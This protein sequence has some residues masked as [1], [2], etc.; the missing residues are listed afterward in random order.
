M[1][2]E[3]WRSRFPE[4]AETDRI[5]LNNGSVGPIPERGLEAA[6][7][8]T[9]VWVDDIDPW[10]NWMDAVD[11]AVEA[12]A[13]LINADVDE[14]AVMT[15]GTQAMAGVA[16]AFDYEERDE[17]V[18]SDLDFPT[19]PHLWYAQ[20][21]GGATLRIAE[22]NDRP[23]VPTEAYVEQ[24]SDRTQ[25]VCTAHAYPFTGGLVDVDAVADAV[26]SRGGY[27]FLDAYQ[28]TGI[29][30][31]DVKE[32]EI[33]MLTTGS[34]KF[35]L[36]G[37]GM[38]FLYVDRDVANKLEPTIRGWFGVKDRFDFD[39]REP[40]YA[41]G[42]RRFEFGTPPV[43][44][45]YTVEAGIELLLEYGIENV[46]ERTVELTGYLIDEVESRGFEVATPH[47]DD[48]R[49]AVVNIQVK[50]PDRTLE[51]LRF[52][53]VAAGARNGGI[54]AGL[55]FYNTKAELDRFIDMLDEVAIPR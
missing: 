4:I 51:T 36:G 28:S 13:E 23:Y 20:E 55:H 52:R 15:S 26:H 44:A 25:L 34:N 1:T 31:I 32:Q 50:H 47:E 30:P 19:A 48:R 27:M 18:T 22:S 5:H 11:G 42:T 53:D 16:S 21:G 24:M 37:V 45:A 7:R 29:V 41:P 35:L 43:P 40:E 12:F 46:R 10:D 49:G 6:E 38:A 2:V 9:D 14:I 54:R 17:V 33:D 3:E 8:Y 39:I